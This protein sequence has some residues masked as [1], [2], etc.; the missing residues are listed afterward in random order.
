MLSSSD[1]SRSSSATPSQPLL[2]SSGTHID[3]NYVAQLFATDHSTHYKDSVSNFQ[4]RQYQHMESLQPYLR[5]L[6]G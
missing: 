4:H 1:F 6:S 2:E 5:C 3:A